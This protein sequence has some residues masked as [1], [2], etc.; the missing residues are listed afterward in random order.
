MKIKNSILIAG[1]LDLEKLVAELLAPGVAKSSSMV[2]DAEVKYP[3]NGKTTM[4]PSQSAGAAFVEPKA[5]SPCLLRPQ[6]QDVLRW[7]QAQDAI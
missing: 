2:V 1:T 5:E 4:T 6:V 7:L 3:T